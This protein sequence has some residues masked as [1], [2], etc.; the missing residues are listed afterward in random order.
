MMLA[1]GVEGTPLRQ[2]C[3]ALC[4]RGAGERGRCLEG[5]QSFESRK[6]SKRA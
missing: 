2:G 1:G 5:A 6:I 3:T 4:V